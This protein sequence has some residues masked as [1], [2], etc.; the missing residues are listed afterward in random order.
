MKK[1]LAT[2]VSRAVFFFLMIWAFALCFASSAHAEEGDV[3]QPDNGIPVVYLNIDESEGHNSIQEM[4]DSPNHSI[5]CV[6]TLSIEV[7]EGFHYSDML[8]EACESV[9]DLEMSVRGRGNSTWQRSPKK[10]F[11]LKL[12]KKADLFGLGKNKHWVLVANMFDPSLLR[13][14]I[15][16]WLGGQMGFAFT[17]RGVPVDLVLTGEEYG[18]QYVGSYYLSENVRVDKNRVNIEELTADDVDPDVITGGY[19]VQNGRQTK[20]WSPDYFTTERG[21]VWATHTPSFDTSDN[22]SALG[23]DD[24]AVEEGAADGELQEEAFAGRELEDAYE[25]PV[26]QEYI[27]KHI[28]YIEDTLYLDD[29]SYRDLMD[30]ESAAKYWLMNAVSLNSDAYDTGS[31]YIY[32]DRDVD[33]V[34]SKLYWGPLWDFDFAWNNRDETEGFEVEHVWLM[35]LFHDTG[36]G[37]FV[38]ELHKQWPTLRAALEELVKEGGLLD[39]YRDETRESANANNEIWH[40]VAPEEFDYDEQVEKLRAWIIARVTW[41]DENFDAV[42]SLV[43][44]VV[45]IADGETYHD[46]FVKDGLTIPEAKDFPA[47]EGQVFIG[48]TDEAGNIV[49][50]ATPIGAD[51]TLK[52]TYISEAEATHGEDVVFKM[53]TDIRKYNSHA[54]MYYIDYTVIPT[55]AQY[56]DVQWSSS[57]ESFATVDENGIV[58]FGDPG[59]EPRLVKLTA[60]LKYGKT[61]T[62]DLWITNG[63]IPLPESIS[64]QTDVIELKVGEQGAFSVVSQPSPAQIDIFEYF[65]G[66]EDV[67]TVDENGVLTAVGVGQAQVRV[68]T[69]TYVGSSGDTVDLAASATV[70]VVADEPPIQQ[71]SLKGATVTGLGSKVYTGSAITPKVT[72]KLD[73]K[74]LV[75]DADYT[76]KYSNNVHVGKA[77]VKVV[78]QGRYKDSIA[79][80]FKI[81]PKGTTIK[82]L[83]ALKKGFKVTWKKQSAQVTGYQVRWSLKKSMKGA[84]TKTIKSKKTTSFKKLKLKSGKRYYVQ[85]RTYKLV[86]GDKYCSKWSAKEHV[87]G[88]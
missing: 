65:S 61:R 16:A 33:G 59:E 20:S 37:G 10:P 49:D 32:K 57:D 44:R 35:P 67:V 62:F 81:L 64:A 38:Q 55:D 11:K 31:T 15:T 75:K 40:P 18:S 51:M 9:Q 30:V 71:V 6:G 47:K 24:E 27:Q 79:K 7:P 56:K 69:V 3:V 85:V 43:H 23:Q 1:S 25:N 17:P 58:T 28:Q 68:E 82:S 13:D 83:K 73:G 4:I 12:D 66:N 5:S 34:V 26:Q 19:L 14:R 36:E 70:V 80:T 48:W 39:K 46:V 72:V 87:T 88:K 22:E 21:A 63:E 45:F 50:A 29:A 84:K 76:V 2:P 86:G 60:K 42:D 8:D 74:T 53:D 78:G 77:T 54:C 41:M 52:A